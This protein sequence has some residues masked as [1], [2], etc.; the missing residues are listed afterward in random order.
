MVTYLIRRIMQGFVVLVASTMLIYFLL[1]L[2]PGGPLSGLRQCATCK[3]GQADINRLGF[4]MGIN[5]E[6]G[7]KYPWYER[8]ARWLFDPN[9]KGADV[10]IGPIH[11]QG[12]G[13]LTG[14]WG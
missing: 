5:D 10:E 4:Q 12:S 7:H 1:T 11:V 9:K 2:I 13:I 3:I 14:D 8:Y 6:Q